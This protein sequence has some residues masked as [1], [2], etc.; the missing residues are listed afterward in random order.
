MARKTKP[1]PGKKTRAE[2]PLPCPRC[3]QL[4]RDR[5]IRSETIMPLKGGAMD[6]L[7]RD[8]SGKCCQDCGS[9]DALLHL[10]PGFVAARIAVG[11]DRQGS[12]RLPGAP[13]GL[14]QTHHMQ[15]T[16]VR[17][18]GVLPV[19]AHHAWL[20]KAVPEW[21]FIGVDGQTLED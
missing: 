4:A 9:A 12:L 20:D 15:A 11:N 7:A 17:D 18:D 10:C 14:I 2:V 5:K 13:L 16:A 19:I 21:P 6:P 3:L 8:G 1:K